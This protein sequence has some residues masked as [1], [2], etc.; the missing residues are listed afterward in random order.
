[1]AET[2]MYLIFITLPC[3]ILDPY[4]PL[5]TS[6]VSVYFLVYF[7]LH[8]LSLSS[9]IG[10][11][12]QCLGNVAQIIPQIVRPFWKVLDER[13]ILHSFNCS[14]DLHTSDLQQPPLETEHL[15]AYKMI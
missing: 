13:M 10:C 5:P 1:M 12:V 6:Q 15:D 7:S 2:H 11:E 8:G 4:R 9:V 3:Y 14:A